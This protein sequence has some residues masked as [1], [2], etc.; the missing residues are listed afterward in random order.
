MLQQD[1]DKTLRD[2]NV[3]DTHSLIASDRVEG[4]RVYGADGKHIGSI[5]RLILGKRDGRVAYAV[6]SFG[7]FMGI[8]H[9]H[10]P[11]PWDK[12]SY[13][14]QLDGYRIDLTKEQIEGAPSYADDDDTWYNDNGRRVYDYY[15]V[16]PYWM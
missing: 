16:P 7:G 1:N 14:T 11:L 15:G 13:D 12:L 10:Y 9:D 6:L 5:E 4:T 3:K 2:P 8:G